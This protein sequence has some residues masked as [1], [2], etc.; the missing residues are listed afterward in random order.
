MP[1]LIVMINQACETLL[2]I[3]YNL[4]VGNRDYLGVST[5]FIRRRLK[6]FI[7]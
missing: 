6:Y 2:I 4:R 7:D 3:E 1:S 5:Q